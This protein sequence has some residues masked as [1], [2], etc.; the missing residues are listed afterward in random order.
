MSGAGK[1]TAFLVLAFAAFC[2]STSPK[3]VPC[4]AC[5][6]SCPVGVV[7]DDKSSYTP[8]VAAECTA[9]LTCTKTFCSGCA[10]KSK[11]CKKKK[12]ESKY[13]KKKKNKCKKTCGLCEEAPSPQPSPSPEPDI[14]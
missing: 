11:N 4:D 7:C 5:S 6:S 9:C 8:T 12:C 2:A 10:D 3:N 14:C 1:L 13:S